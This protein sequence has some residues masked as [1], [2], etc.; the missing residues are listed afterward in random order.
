M[1]QANGG[2]TVPKFVTPE[3]FGG[4]KQDDGSARSEASRVRECFSPQVTLKGLNMLSGGP[5]ASKAARSALRTS[6]CMP[7][8]AKSLAKVVC[9]S[10]RGVSSK[11]P[12]PSC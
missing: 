11:A 2:T 4:P 10:S 3:E 6:S 9:A 8:S 7:T 12:G 1:T 5:A